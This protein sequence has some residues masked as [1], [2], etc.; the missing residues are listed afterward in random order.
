MVKKKPAEISP[1][2]FLF[3]IFSFGTLMVLPFFIWEMSYSN[4]V[5]WNGKLIGSILYLG[6]AAS[7]V[8][9]LIWNMAIRKLGAGRTALFGNLIPVFSSIEAA[10]ILHEDFTWVHVTSMVIVFVG[11]LLANLQPLPK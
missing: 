2:N 3:V 1:V 9:F 11:I 4:Q 5:V 7:V 10:V 6:I 8:C